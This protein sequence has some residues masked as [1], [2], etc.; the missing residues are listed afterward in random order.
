MRNTLTVCALIAMSAIA[1]AQES[2]TPANK[3]AA[4]V[5]GVTLSSQAPVAPA[6]PVK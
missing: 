6:A 4:P 1:Y 5:P 2:L 3:A